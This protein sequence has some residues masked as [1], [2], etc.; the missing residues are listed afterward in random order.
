MSARQLARLLDNIALFAEFCREQGCWDAPWRF[1]SDHARFL[2]FLH[3]DRLPDYAPHEDFAAEVV[4]LSGLPGAGK[5]H[6]AATHLPGW[7]V[8]ALDDLRQEL[9]VLPTDKQG[10][11]LQR[12]A[13]TGPRAS[14]CRSVL[15][16]ER[17]E[18]E[19]FGARRV[20]PPVCG[21]SGADTH[22]LRG[23]VRRETGAAEPAAAGAGAAQGHR[24]PAPGAGRC[25]T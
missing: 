12:G 17:H 7:P 20:H 6:W 8:I 19:S 14:A 10:A 3:E 1:P 4:L 16:M 9:D 25:L 5:D 13:R 22:R 11:V 21:V 24:A 2:Y 18:S 23:G 15:R